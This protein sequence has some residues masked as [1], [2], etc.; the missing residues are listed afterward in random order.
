MKTTFTHKGWFGICP[1]YFANL[2]S[3]SPVVHERRPWM[4]PLMMIS[5]FMYGVA[6]ACT[7]LVRPD[8]EPMW[9]LRVTGV[10]SPP[11]V[12]DLP[13]EDA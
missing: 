3:D 8:W 10:I 11:L 2:Q 4:L 5:E 1:V 9:P 13:T 12:L 7:R 6:F